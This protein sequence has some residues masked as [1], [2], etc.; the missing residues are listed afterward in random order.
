[1]KRASWSGSNAITLKSSQALE[2]IAVCGAIGPRTLS[3]LAAVRA[4]GSRDHAI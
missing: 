4:V 1:M 2:Q 3:T